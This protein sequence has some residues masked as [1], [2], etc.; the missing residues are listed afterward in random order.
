MN[1]KKGNHTEN[2]EKIIVY[3]FE[4]RFIHAMTQLETLQGSEM[5]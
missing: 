3:V 4:E 5:Q 2:I 1:L